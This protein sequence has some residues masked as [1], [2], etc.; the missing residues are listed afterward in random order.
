MTG[1]N[2]TQS[3]SS[4]DSVSNGNRGV[5]SGM[6]PIAVLEVTS[7]GSVV[8]GETRGGGEGRGRGGEG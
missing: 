5:G 3:S 2:I 4:G 7:G 8:K 6:L 1:S